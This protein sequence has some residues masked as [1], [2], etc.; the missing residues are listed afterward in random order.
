V[1]LSIY[2]FTKVYATGFG[3]ELPTWKFNIAKLGM[4]IKN[5]P[6]VGNKLIVV[7]EL[8]HLASSVVVQC[9]FRLF[10]FQP[11]AAFSGRSH[12]GNCLIWTARGREGGSV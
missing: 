7:R 12:V 6:E 5:Y 1:G 11:L 3:S 2:A 8:S 4:G 10:F 9:Y